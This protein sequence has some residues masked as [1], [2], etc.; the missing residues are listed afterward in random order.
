MSEAN[1][2]RAS[3]GVPAE[4]LTPACPLSPLRRR[5]DPHLPSQHGCLRSSRAAGVRTQPAAHGMAAFLEHVAGAGSLEGV[6]RRHRLSCAE[7]KVG[8][9]NYKQSRGQPPEELPNP[10]LGVDDLRI[11]TLMAATSPGGVALKLPAPT[12]GMSR[13]HARISAEADGSHTL[14]SASTCGTFVNRKR[15]DPGSVTLSDGDIII[16]G[17]LAT[18]CERGGVLGPGE[19]GTPPAFSYRYVRERPAA[20]TTGEGA[21]AGAEAAAAAGGAGD[22]DVPKEE[23]EERRRRRGSGGEAESSPNGVGQGSLPHPSSQRVEAPPPP[24]A[25]AAA[26]SEEQPARSPSAPALEEPRSPFAAEAAAAAMPPLSLAAEHDGGEDGSMGALHA[27]GAAVEACA[28]LRPDQQQQKSEPS[29]PSL[30]PRAAAAAAAEGEAQLPM[31]DEY[32]LASGAS[33]VKYPVAQM[34]QEG[35]TAAGGVDAALARLRRVLGL[36]DI[37]SSQK[38]KRRRTTVSPP[39]PPPLSAAGVADAAAAEAMQAA[40]QHQALRRWSR[41]QIFAP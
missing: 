24:R 40:A 9:P 10:E 29:E 8:R 38:V 5:A 34:V 22:S 21:T 17:G 25:D 7:V 20:A 13:V 41:G 26:A 16:F 3:G 36:P 37:N 33:A 35:R 28:S 12:A 39:R 19:S 30:P 31:E 32:G 14:S 18:K 4:A 23:E 2:L 27:A 15:V 6:P 11:D 1:K